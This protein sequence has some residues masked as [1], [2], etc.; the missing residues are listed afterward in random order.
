MKY[1]N[2]LTV[3]RHD[4]LRIVVR[5][6]GNNDWAAYWAEPGEDVQSGSLRKLMPSLATDEYAFRIVEALVYEMVPGRLTYRP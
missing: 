3:E 6:G 2:I 5:R 1:D 4:G